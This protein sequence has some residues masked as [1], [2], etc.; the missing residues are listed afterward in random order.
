M[1]WAESFTQK[2]KMIEN[3]GYLSEI[4]KHDKIDQKCQ[5]T[6]EIDKNH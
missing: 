6:T 1:K 3:Y 5:K 2:G 4:I